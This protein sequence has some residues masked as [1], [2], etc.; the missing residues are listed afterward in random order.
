MLDDGEAVAEEAQPRDHPV[1]AA[2]ELAE[3]GA[4]V[5]AVGSLA[6]EPAVEMDGGIDAER[7][8]PS[9]CTDRALPSA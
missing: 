1:R 3:H 6:V 9:A 8:A 4:R 7:D 5:V 2:G